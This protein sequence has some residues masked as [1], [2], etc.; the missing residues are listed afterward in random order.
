MSTDRPF[1]AIPPSLGIMLTIEAG[2]WTNKAAAIAGG[3]G[4]LHKQA[5]A[6]IPQMYESINVKGLRFTITDGA[7]DW[8]L[9][10]YQ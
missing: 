5:R 3:R 2:F 7:Q 10:A 4:P 1:G 6:I 9:A 8:G